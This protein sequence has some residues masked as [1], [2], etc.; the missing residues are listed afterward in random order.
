[1][2]ERGDSKT[3]RRLQKHSIY[4]T[5]MYNHSRRLSAP[6]TSINISLPSHPQ[7]LLRHGGHMWPFAKKGTGE[8]PRLRQGWNSGAAGHN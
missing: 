5:S 8:K 6:D 4:P 1:M 3:G 7:I 2:E